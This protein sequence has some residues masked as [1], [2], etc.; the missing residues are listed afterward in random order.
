MKKKQ[1]YRFGMG[2]IG[3]TGSLPE[4]W[5]S[6]QW[7]ALVCSGF[8]GQERRYLVRV[9]MY[10]GRRPRL[11]THRLADGVITFQL[12]LT[13]SPCPVLHVMSEDAALGY[14]GRWKALCGK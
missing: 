12:R 1:G 13:A 10:R 9:E 7:A 3:V 14:R 11:P 2:G 8:L 4:H 6:S 5:E